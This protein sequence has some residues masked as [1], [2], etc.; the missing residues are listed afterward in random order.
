MFYW[1]TRFQPNMPSMHKIDLS[2][3]VLIWISLYWDK[4]L[5]V[6]ANSSEY[7]FLIRIFQNVKQISTFETAHIT[8]QH[9]NKATNLIF[10]CSIWLIF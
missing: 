10:V 8:S 7:S 1:R 4:S 3:E 6:L 2:N 5:N 9:V